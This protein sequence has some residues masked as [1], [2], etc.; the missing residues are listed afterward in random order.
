MDKR[1]CYDILYIIHFIETVVFLEDCS[2]KEQKSGFVE[3]I[4]QVNLLILVSTY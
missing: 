2:Y 1:L 4:Y 3:L